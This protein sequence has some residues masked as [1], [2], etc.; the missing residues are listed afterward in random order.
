MQCHCD[1]AAE[2][3]TEE[4]LAKGQD[5][6][7]QCWQ[8]RDAVDTAVNAAVD[9]GVKPPNACFEIAPNEVAVNPFKGSFVP[10]DPSKLTGPHFFLGHSI[11]M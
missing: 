10:P 8:R 6:L 9:R 4:L 5:L 7:E 1:R 2:I 11:K 3:A